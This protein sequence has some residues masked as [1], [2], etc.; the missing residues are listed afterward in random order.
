MASPSTPPFGYILLAQ[1]MGAGSELFGQR[2][3]RRCH[4]HSNVRMLV[5]ASLYC[6]VQAYVL[7]GAAQVMLPRQWTGGQGSLTMFQQVWDHPG[8]LLNT[9]VNAV[10][11]LAMIILLREPLGPLLVVLAFLFGSFLVDPFQAAVGL[12]SGGS[13]PPDAVLLGLAGAALCVVDVPTAVVARLLPAWCVRC[14]RLQ[15]RAYGALETQPPQQHGA[16]EAAADASP[17]VDASTVGEQQR[18]APGRSGADSPHASDRDAFV[19]DTGA[20]SMPVRSRG[21]GG[22]GGGADAASEVVIAPAAPAAAAGTLLHGAFVATAFVTLAV[23][24]AMGLVFM[25]YYEHHAG[26]S[27]FGYAAVDAG[28]L[29]ATM[30]PLAALI[31]AWPLLRRLTGEPPWSEAAVT[32]PHFGHTL[33][34]TWYELCEVPGGSGSGG[35]GDDAAD[36]VGSGLASGGHHPWGLRP[37]SRWRHV[38]RAIKAGLRQLVRP[39]SYWFTLVPFH[40][41]E[42]LRTLLLF[43]LVTAFDIEATYL[44]MTLVRIALVWV[45]SLAACTLLRAW[46]GIADAEA[47]ATLHPANLAVRGAGTLLLALAVLRLKGLL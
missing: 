40:G 21:G 12:P 1:A 43:W 17:S 33:A 3:G 46:V 45:V 13:L 31:D 18:S 2:L 28:F 11:W 39:W 7:L 44:Q 41:I 37:R 27:P 20:S 38:R 22:S 32:P 6:S 4:G 24:T 14:C 9:A 29:P 8:L 26:L 30:L 25:T 35:E 47:A 10:Y 34:R 42:F 5:S 36:W 15:P 23:T 16:A 19:V